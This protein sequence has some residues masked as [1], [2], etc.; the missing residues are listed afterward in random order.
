MSRSLHNF[1]RNDYKSKILHLVGTYKYIFNKKYF[2]LG[3]TNKLVSYP[4]IKLGVHILDKIYID[5]SKNSG[6]IT[7]TNRLDSCSVV[8]FPSL[9]PD[10]ENI[11]IDGDESLSSTMDIKTNID[12]D[13]VEMIGL[14]TIHNYLNVLRSLVYSNKKPAYYLNRVFKLSCAQISSQDKSAEYTLTLTVLHP[15]QMSKSTTEQPSASF[16]NENSVQSS[17]ID[18]A[19]HLNSEVEIKDQGE[20]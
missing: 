19:F 16:Y 18:A 7:G 3:I 20:F 2:V 10:H 8:V 9:N 13:G 11:Q 1:D 12:K 4:E 14:D 17:N 6:K 15:K 5:I